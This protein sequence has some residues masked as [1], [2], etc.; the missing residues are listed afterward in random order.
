MEATLTPDSWNTNILSLN[1]TNDFNLPYSEEHSVTVLPLN[2]TQE[3]LSSPFNFKSEYLIL[4]SNVGFKEKSNGL[5][6]YT[7][8]SDTLE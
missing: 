4:T 6:K 7:L 8:E 2:L 1:S 5:G 3:S